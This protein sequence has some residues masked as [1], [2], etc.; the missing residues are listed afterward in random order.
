MFKH[1]YFTRDDIL[2]KV[3]SSF[4]IFSL[5]YGFIQLI[6]VCVIFRA[7]K[8]FVVKWYQFKD[9][10]TNKILWH[11]L[12]QRFHSTEQLL[13]NTIEDSSNVSDVTPLNALKSPNLYILMIIYSLSSQS[14][15]FVSALYKVLYILLLDFW[16]G[17]K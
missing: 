3:P 5:I 16:N 17:Y 6:G 12:Q 10:N 14:V 8:H 9:K 2:N 13:S 4:L 1:R 11:F 15:P 7:D